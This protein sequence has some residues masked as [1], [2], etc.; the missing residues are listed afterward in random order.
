[1]MTVKNRPG[2]IVKIPPT[3][4]TLLLPSPLPSVTIR[5]DLQR[6]AIRALHP[7]LPSDLPQVFQAILPTWKKNLSDGF[8]IHGSPSPSDLLSPHYTP[9]LRSLEGMSQSDLQD[10]LKIFLAGDTKNQGH[11]FQIGLTDPLIDV[12]PVSPTKMVLPP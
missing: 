1:M 3:L 8:T 6:T 4:P 2:Q 9:N 5:P 12:G 11:G 10:G 7:L